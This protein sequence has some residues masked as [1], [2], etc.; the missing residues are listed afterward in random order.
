MS[1]KDFNTESEEIEEESKNVV[2]IESCSFNVRKC[3]QKSIRE[4]QPMT[5]MVSFN[6]KVSFNII[7]KHK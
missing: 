6:M 7:S 3:M 1:Y 5:L 4:A 2:S